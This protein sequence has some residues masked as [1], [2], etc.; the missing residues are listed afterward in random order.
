MNR[1]IF[2]VKECYERAVCIHA[3][4]SKAA[5]E[6]LSNEL[7]RKPLSGLNIVTP[8]IKI[9]EPR[10]LKSRSIIDCT[11]TATTDN[12]ETIPTPRYEYIAENER[13]QPAIFKYGMRLRGCSPGCQPTWGYIG[14]ADDLMGKYYDIIRY[15]RALTEQERKQYELDYLGVESL[16]KYLGVYPKRV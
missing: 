2:T 12:G 8:E 3:D 4:S 6:A 16:N 11:A 5:Y 7:E 15:D 1:Y 10:N 9:A 14:R 13:L